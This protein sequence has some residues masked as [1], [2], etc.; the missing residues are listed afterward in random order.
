MST[1]AKQHRA[2][3]QVNGSPAAAARTRKP[4][5]KQMVLLP[6]SLEDLLPPDHPA[7]VIW[8]VLEQ[9]DLSRFYEPIRSRQG[10][11][12]REAIDPQVLIALWLLAAVEGIGS[13]RRLAELCGHHAAYRWVC[14][15]G[16]IGAVNYHT[17][18]D[19]RVGHKQALDEL[20]TQVLGRLTHAGLVQVTR[21]TQDG[22][23]VRASAGSGSFVERDTLAA[24]LAEARQHV[25]ALGRLADEGPAE[26]AER[27]R[28]AAERNAAERL[29]RLE[30]AME[31]LTKVEAAK[32]Q[33]KEKPSKHRPAKASTSDP[34]A[35]M[36]RMPDGGFRPAYNVQLAQDPI[37]RAVVGVAVAPDSSDKDQAE[38]MRQQ[39]ES[40][41]G[42]RVLEQVVDGNY[43]TLE[44]IDEAAA[45]GVTLYVPVPKP[46]NKEQDR[47]APRRD[48]SPAVAAWR[49]RMN[50]PEARAIYRTR[51]STAE[52]VNG[53][54][55]TH[56]GLAR[57]LV[58]GAGNVLCVAMWSA[59]AYNLMHFGA[60]L[61]L[62]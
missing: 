19:F 18:N 15:G 36:Q 6:C 23:K 11:A 32:A 9:L 59:L 22:T 60:A 44:G 50:T 62:A 27:Q 5:R 21:I 14:G 61:L 49:R 26:A 13:G 25:A 20:F 2:E 56:R 58:R 40:R 48:D 8:A 51:A 55:K 10:V 57:L 24:K 4:N 12:G 7:R 42:Q 38:P 31:E 1:D 37:S 3:Q 41:T 39:V 17:L 53:D 16:D 33:Q 28:V 47:Y 43:L 54:L 35:R 34:Q 30:R 45:A 46:K 52:T 29:T